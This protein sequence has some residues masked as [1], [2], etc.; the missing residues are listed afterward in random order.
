MKEGV[1]VESTRVVISSPVI[2]TLPLSIIPN[3]VAALKRSK[4][5]EGEDH[6]TTMNT[7]HSLLLISFSFLRIILVVSGS[8]SIDS[9]GGKGDWWSISDPTAWRALERRGMMLPEMLP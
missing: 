8:E 7:L 5:S 9:S 2:H 1:K 6:R 4:A 3:A